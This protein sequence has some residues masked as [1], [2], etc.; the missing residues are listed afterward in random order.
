MNSVSPDREARATNPA[1][2]SPREREAVDRALMGSTTKMI[3]FDMGISNS[4]VRVLLA[5]AARKVGA[6]SRRELLERIDARTGAV[7]AQKP[8]ADSGCPRVPVM[9]SADAPESDHGSR[10]FDGAGDG[11][12]AA[13]GQVRAIVIIVDDVVAEELEQMPFAEHDQIIEQL[14]GCADDERGGAEASDQAGRQ[15]WRVRLC[16]YVARGR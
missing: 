8:V 9:E 13:K 14:A 4:T 12:I 1:R 6:R 11:R 5:R 3:A 7:V 10:V 15:R 16:C 2:L